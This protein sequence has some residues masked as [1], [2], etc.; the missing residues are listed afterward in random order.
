MFQ[1]LP[2]DVLK[3]VLIEYNL[4][5]FLL[6][7]QAREEVARLQRV[8]L[9]HGR[10][11]SRAERLRI[12]RHLLLQ[13]E[14]VH[15]LVEHRQRARPLGAAHKSSLGKLIGRLLCVD[16]QRFDALSEHVYFFQNHRQLRFEGLLEDFERALLAQLL[17]LQAVQHVEA[18]FEEGSEEAFGWAGLI[19]TDGLLEM[20]QN[21][22][23]AEVIN[24]QEV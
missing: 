21:R 24:D 20:S 1:L 22:L 23:L 18:E 15:D 14:E 6:R 2:L 7:E 19:A 13:D 10:G 11:C 16:F 8:R 3:V 5:D 9:V 17:F 12:S 4:L